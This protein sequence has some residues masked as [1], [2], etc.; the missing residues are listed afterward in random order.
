HSPGS[1]TDFTAGT[2]AGGISGTDS[3]ANSYPAT[4]VSL[5]ASGYDG[6]VGW[7]RF[8]GT[9]TLADTQS[10]LFTTTLGPNQGIHAVVG[11]PTAVMPTVG[12]AHY[13]L[14]GA[15]APTLASGAVAPGNV[16]GGG[17][18]V[19]FF[20]TPALIGTLNLAIGGKNF[21]LSFSGTF[22]GNGLGLGGTINSFASSSNGGCGLYSCTAQTSGFF[23]GANA[24]RAGMAYS[25]TGHTLDA[26]AI[27]GA[28]VY[29]QTVS[30]AR[31]CNPSSC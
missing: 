15:T 7:G 26:T 24:A 4:G 11:I 5:P 29:S 1:V 8:Y 16:M 2:L 18:D 31:G 3:V 25:I 17:L 13:A 19:W 14:T 20:G 9:L 27:R 22:T 28:A 23:A 6:I 21:D 12:S 10:G 30:T